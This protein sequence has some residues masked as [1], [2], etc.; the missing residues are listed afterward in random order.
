[1]CILIRVMVSIFYIPIGELST[2]ELLKNKMEKG[3]DCP[4]QIVRNN[5]QKF[6]LPNEILDIRYKIYAHSK[7]GTKRAFTC[8]IEL[9]HKLPFIIY[10]LIQ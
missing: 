2:F 1:M 8:E 9:F 10:T 7:H 4:S 5:Y 6:F 3:K